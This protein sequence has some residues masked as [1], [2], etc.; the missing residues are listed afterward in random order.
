[1][2][3]RAVD[4]HALMVRHEQDLADTECDRLRR[5]DL[6][7]YRTLDPD[8]LQERCRGLVAAFVASLAGRPTLLGDYL[9]KVAA[10]RVDEGYFLQEVQNALN[11]LEERGWQ[12]V[13]AETPAPDQ[14]A[15][16]GV[17]T[18]TI[19]AAKDRLA[20][21]Y[22]ERQRRAE[23]RARDLQARLDELFAGTDEGPVEEG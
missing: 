10:D 15:Q 11:F 3:A 13:A 6:P 5:S 20:R 7:H 18:Q 21:V 17:V 23:S 9:E 16:L 22:L 19:G 2:T 8:R 1:M 14:V 4:L 12:I